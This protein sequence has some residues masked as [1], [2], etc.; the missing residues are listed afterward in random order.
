[1]PAIQNTVL[2]LFFCSWLPH[3][4]HSWLQKVPWEETA[5]CKR[6][7]SFTSSIS[8]DINRTRHYSARCYAYSHTDKLFIYSLPRAQLSLYTGAAES[9]GL[10]SAWPLNALKPI[11]STPA[12][13]PGLSQLRVGFCLLTRRFP[14][15]LLWKVT[16]LEFMPSLKD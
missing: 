2:M 4:L 13:R 6:K 3:H 10:Q 1:M 12:C 7:W 8:C 15:W 14:A 11:S 5:G 16:V 9:T